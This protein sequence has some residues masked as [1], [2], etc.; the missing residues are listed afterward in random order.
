[1]AINL[2]RNT[3]LFVSTLG[4]A[5]NTGRDPQNTFEVPILDGYS[6]SQEAD[7]ATITLNE[8][9]D[10]P[11]RGQ[12]I[13]NTAINPA[14]I[15]FS[16]YVRP[17]YNNTQSKH[18]ALEQVLWEALTG[19]G[20]P[21]SASHATKNGTNAV[22]GASYMEANFEQSNE[23]EL[24]KL[25]MFFKIDNTVYKISE[26]AL[27]SAEIDFAIDAIAMINWS[28]QGTTVDEL[29]GTDLT[30]F[31]SWV[32]A[33]TVYDTLTDIHAAGVP[34]L[35][36]KNKLSSMTLK[37]TSG[38]NVATEG[39][40]TVSGPFDT[41]AAHGLTAATTPDFDV[42]VDGG[43]VQ[44]VSIDVDTR[45][46]LVTVG[47][48]VAEMNYQ[49][50]GV[51]VS[52]SDAGDLVFTSHTAGTGSTM[53]VA[54]GTPDLLADLAGYTAINSATAGTGTGKTYNVPLTG[55]SV[56]IENNVTFLTPEE[57]GVVNQ[58]IGSFTGTR[59]IS[60]NIT[61]YLNS[62][63]NNTGGLLADLVSDTTTVTHD[64]EVTM[65]MGGGANTPRVDFI[66]GNAHLVIPSVNVEDVISTEINFTALG[67]EI[68]EADEL[69]VRYVAQ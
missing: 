33:E 35:F 28:A 22:S 42:T 61:A 11:V 55:G 4:N 17:F 26:V 54:A 66:M 46:D 37:A 57:L 60:G 53:L 13:F 52:V 6:F 59:A 68:T 44:T 23:H 47:D 31:N 16:T 2:S 30:D 56:T 51:T 63:A 19:A 36:I 58:S 50:D 21:G 62:G 7:S 24:L 69:Y 20:T 18:G 14:D 67:S 29:S 5:D 41:T 65:S 3:R 32:T 27:T 10:A 9:G 12:K 64:F 43:T 15:S 1:M 25:F 39:Y 34:A 8:A 40:Q 38:S 45:T 48:V 49:L